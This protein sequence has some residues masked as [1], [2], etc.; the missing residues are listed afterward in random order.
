MAENEEGQRDLGDQDRC[1]R[2]CQAQD[3]D[4]YLDE[5]RAAK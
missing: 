4:Y 3:S 5:H 2:E 1:D